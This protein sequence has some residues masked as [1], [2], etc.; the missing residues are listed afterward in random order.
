M[1]KFFPGYISH[2]IQ[3]LYRYYE[4]TASKNFD[5]ITVIPVLLERITDLRREFLELQSRDDLTEPDQLKRNLRSFQ[6]LLMVLEEFESFGLPVVTHYQQDF[7]GYLTSVLKKLCCEIGCPVAPPH[8]CAI[9]TGTSGQGRDYYWYH[10]YFD[11]IFIP[12]AEKFSI[13][14]LP[15]LLHELGHHILKTYPDFFLDPFPD[16]LSQY[17]EN[18]ERVL[19]VEDIHDPDRKAESMRIFL[20]FWP[21]YWCHELICDMIAIYCVGEAYAWTNLKIC[22]SYRPDESIYYYTD[23]HPPDSYRMDAI[24]AMLKHLGINSKDVRKTWAK[25]AEIFRHHK[26]PLYDNYFPLKLTEKMAQHIFNI[27]DDIGLVP[28]TD[29]LQKETTIICKLNKAWDLFRTNPKRF[30]KME[31]SLI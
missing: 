7:D 16:W 18:L 9:S 26:L 14:N 13:L 29:N 15:D 19:V 12:A 21:S 1:R 4:F 11:T 2:I 6:T 8:V 10:S 5:D 30:Q 27:C 24:L 25:Y 20:E 28:C 3:L 31:K 23:S 17:H 22:Q